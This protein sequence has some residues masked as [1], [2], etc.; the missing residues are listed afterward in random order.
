MRD[1]L[2]II[3][4]AAAG[5]WLGAH[6]VQAVGQRMMAGTGSETR[7][8]WYRFTGNLVRPLYIPAVA[9]LVITG[10]WMVL[11]IDA[12]SFADT[13]VIIRLTVVVV[14]T[15]L[16]FAVFEPTSQAAAR[17]VES[18]PR[19]SP[20]RQP[21]AGGIRGHRHVAA[22]LCHHGDGSP[23]GRVRRRISSLASGYRAIR[24]SRWPN[25]K[26]SGS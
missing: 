14:G 20:L 4:M 2:L 24:L 22:P 10:V 9:L 23:P 11:S 16:G 1:V 15:V 3:H 21:Q 6:L 19:E 18:R 7:A 5:T 25:T 8:G 13:F 26:P 17:A 12:Y